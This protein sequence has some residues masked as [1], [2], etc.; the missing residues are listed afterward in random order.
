MLSKLG[1]SLLFS[2]GGVWGE[3]A[4]QIRVNKCYMMTRVLYLGF[5]QLRNKWGRA[6]VGVGHVRY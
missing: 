1:L 6:G 2:F 5:P 3:A 4:G